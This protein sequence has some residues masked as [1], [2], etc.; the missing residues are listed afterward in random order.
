MTLVAGIDSSTQ[1][2]K[3]VLVDADSGAVV[4]TGRSDH[5]DG[6]EVDPRAWW[7]A[8]QQAGDGLLERAAAVAVGGSST[9]WSSSTRPVR[10]CAP[11]CCGTTRVRPAP[12]AT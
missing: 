2:C 3:V 6:T 9:A 8:L 11:R 12:P 4:A 7:D 5:P 1:S 10:W